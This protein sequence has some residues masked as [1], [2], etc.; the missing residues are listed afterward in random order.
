MFVAVPALCVV[1][2]AAGVEWEAFVARRWREDALVFPRGRERCRGEEKWKTS[3][4][5]P[6]KI[7]GNRVRTHVS[8][9]K[10]SVRLLTTQFTSRVFL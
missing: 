9:V 10:S 2:D 4:R 6:K 5:R 7:R 8:V 3:R 1:V